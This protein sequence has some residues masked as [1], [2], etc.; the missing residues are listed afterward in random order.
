MT[1]L[2]HD[3][4]SPL[5]APHLTQILETKIRYDG[6]RQEFRCHLIERSDEH[7]VVLHIAERIFHVAD[8]VIPPGTITFGHFWAHRP[9]N[10]Y[11]WMSKVGATLGHYFNI[12]DGTTWTADALTWRD[13]IVDVLLRPDGRNDVLDRHELPGD[14]P[15]AVAAPIHAATDSVLGQANHLR[16]HLEAEADR[17]WPLAFGTQRP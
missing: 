10:A 16:G 2:S 17:L 3:K 15:F 5:D 9:Y 7:L 4:P 1:C 6:R 12:A 14:L 8:L 13:L 11:H